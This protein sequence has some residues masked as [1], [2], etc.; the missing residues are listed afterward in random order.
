MP[1]RE[2]IGSLSI[3]A[4]MPQIELAAGEDMTALVLRI[5]EPLNDADETLLRAFADRYGVVFYLQPKGAGHRLSFL[6]ADGAG[7]VVSAT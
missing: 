5:L 6:P 4:A 7:A 1:L 3:N 2:L